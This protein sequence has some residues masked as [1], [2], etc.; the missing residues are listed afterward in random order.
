MR[1]R[2][3]QQ[4]GLA[5]LELALTLPL[6]LLLL[7]VP[8]FLGRLTWHYLAGLGAAEDAAWYMA[9]ESVLRMDQIDGERAA[10]ATAT[11]LAQ[12]E[13]AELNPAGEYFPAPFVE[14]YCDNS[15]CA[16]V[17]F[18]ATGYRV[19][20]WMEIGDPFFDHWGDALN[21]HSGV[22]MYANVE[23]TNVQR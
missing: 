18:L 17:P 6:L 5:A 19:L 7:A 21:Q 11:A 2:A 20:V 15:Y 8:L 10:Q 4:R 3:D 9:Q 16:E 14:I 23:V 22:F 13:L 12:A 1:R